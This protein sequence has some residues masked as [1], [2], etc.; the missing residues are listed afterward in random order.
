MQYPEMTLR[1][2]MF[3]N[4]V[5]E[6]KYWHKCLEDEE[7]DDGIEYCEERF[8]DV[9]DACKEMRLLLIDEMEEYVTNCKT[10]NVPIDISYW[11]IKIQLN[12]TCFE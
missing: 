5:D 4:L 9:L 2:E 1:I 6:L 7:G 11:R 3:G 10:N 8:E 12:E